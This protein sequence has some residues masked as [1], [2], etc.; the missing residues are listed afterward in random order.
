MCVCACVGGG[1]DESR[2]ARRGERREVIRVSES[3]VEPQCLA[4]ND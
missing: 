3:T 1:L 2:E 4:R